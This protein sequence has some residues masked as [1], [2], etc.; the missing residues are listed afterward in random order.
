MNEKKNKYEKRLQFQQKM[1]SR[2]S[3]QIDS[4]KLEIQEL[5]NKIIEKDEIINSVTLLR[6]ELTENVNQVKE[7]KKQYSVLIEELKK[8]KSIIDKD[9]YKGR[10]KLI[11]FLIK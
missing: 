10:W 7:Y 6:N 11:K 5:K 2:Q 1:I 9:I 8:M 4:L 3:E